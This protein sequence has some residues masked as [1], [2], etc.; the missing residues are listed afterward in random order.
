MNNGAIVSNSSLNSFRDLGLHAVAS[1]SSFVISSAA[2][3]SNSNFPALES[4]SLGRVS[5]I[6]AREDT[7]M[8]DLSVFTKEG[9]QISGKMLSEDEVTKYLTKE[10][11]FSSEAIYRANY[12][13]TSSSCL[14]YTSP[15]PR[16]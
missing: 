2:Q 6:L 16:D 10:N 15:S 4:G 9:I 8:S 1:G 12:L 14:L 7:G 11:G 13:P 5:G 3:A